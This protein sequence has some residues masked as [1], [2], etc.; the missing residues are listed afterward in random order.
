M[1]PYIFVEKLSGKRINGLAQLL[2][3][4]RKTVHNWYNNDP[5]LLYL[6]CKGYFQAKLDAAKDMDNISH[7][8]LK[9]P[10][11][12]REWI[13]KDIER[14]KQEGRYGELSD[15]A[16]KIIEERQEKEL[17]RKLGLD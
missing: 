10:E 13:L 6:V 14:I 11:K 9:D 15:H 5:V 4:E 3:R 1:K 8:M 16:A 7:W 2:N 12:M 17:N